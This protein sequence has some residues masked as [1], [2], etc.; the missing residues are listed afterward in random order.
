MDSK[1]KIRFYNDRCRRSLIVPGSAQ[2][3]RDEGC[4]LRVVATQGFKA[5]VE[6]N[7]ETEIIMA[8]A[9]FDDFNES[10]DPYGEHDFVSLE[11][12]GQKLFAK[13]DYYDQSLEHGS[14]DLANLALTCR[15]LTLMLAEEY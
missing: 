1:E 5:F 9:L 12:Q 14:P 2:K 11:Y 13:I 6:E 3:L 10:N 4:N 8:I 15:V 7:N